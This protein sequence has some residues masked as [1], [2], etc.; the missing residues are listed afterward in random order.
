MGHMCFQGLNTAWTKALTGLR[1][2]P[3]SCDDTGSLL[4]SLSILLTTPLLSSLSHP[5]F[6]ICLHRACFHRGV[7]H[8]LALLRP[9]LPKIPRPPAPPLLPC[10]SSSTRERELT[11][12]ANTRDCHEPQILLHKQNNNLSSRMAMRIDIPST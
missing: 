12:S 11:I 10:H 5:R 7:R 2:H 9:T 1:W 3:R 4:G 8:C 6:L